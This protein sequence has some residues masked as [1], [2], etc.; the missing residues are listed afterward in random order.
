MKLLDSVTGSDLITINFGITSGILT[1][2]GLISIYVSLNTQHS[3]QK[4][5]ELYWNIVSLTKRDTHR[6][7]HETREK[8]NQDFHLYQHI[9]D[10]GIPERST[11]TIINLSISAIFFVLFVWIISIWLLIR[12]LNKLELIVASIIW[13]GSGIILLFFIKFLQKLKTILEDQGLLPPSELLNPAN[14]KGINTLGV[15]STLIEIHTIEKYRSMVGPSPV[16][17]YSVYINKPTFTGLE[18]KAQLLMDPTVWYNPT[19]TFKDGVTVELGWDATTISPKRELYSYNVEFYKSKAI[20][21]KKLEIIIDIEQ[22]EIFDEYFED[23][24]IKNKEEITAK[25]M[26]DEIKS[27][28]FDLMIQ[29]HTRIGDLYH[30]AVAE[31]YDV[32]EIDVNINPQTVR[33]GALGLST[34]EDLDYELEAINDPINTSN[35]IENHF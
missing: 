27:V 29:V 23:A 5:K 31:F 12:P 2:V 8:F 32:Q 25:I 9:Y 24:Q 18:I 28:K 6:E 22:H 1:L 10:E 13:L 14:D 19:V 4:C 21:D 11:K 35:M 33:P 16:G 3:L 20:F 30:N 26:N 15:I 17:K 7:K 34:E